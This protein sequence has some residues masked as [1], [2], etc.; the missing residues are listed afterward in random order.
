MSTILLYFGL[1]ILALAICYKIPGLEHLVKPVVELIFW[2]FKTMLEHSGLWFV[3]A[4]K[5]LIAAH[6]SLFEH[7][8]KSAQSIDITYDLRKNDK[9]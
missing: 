8:T 1:A 3:F 7:L 6:V 2:V 4:I 5:T 9:Q